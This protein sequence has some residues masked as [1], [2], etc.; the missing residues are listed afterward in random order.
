MRTRQRASVLTNESGPPGVR[1]G[2]YDAD[3]L[4]YETALRDRAQRSAWRHTTRCC[5]WLNE[6]GEN[7]RA[8]ARADGDRRW[9]A[10]RRAHRG[11]GLRGGPGV[12]REAGFLE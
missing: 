4:D 5:R 10:S 8:R 9:G 2:M 12:R 6:R 11:R 1:R 3:V 7:S